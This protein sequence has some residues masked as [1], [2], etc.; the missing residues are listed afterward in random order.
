MSLK[1]WW[2]EGKKRKEKIVCVVY[3]EECKAICLSPNHGWKWS[4][5]WRRFNLW[6]WRLRKASHV[7]LGA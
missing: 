7:E 2:E 3:N 1:I 4:L 6:Q 5:G